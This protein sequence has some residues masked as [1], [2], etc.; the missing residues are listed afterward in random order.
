LTYSVTI[1]LDS[2]IKLYTICYAALTFMFNKIV[3][4]LLCLIIAQ[5]GHGEKRYKEG[6]IKINV[7]LLS[8]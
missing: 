4:G 6:E 3:E 5:Y 7:A 1:A 8:E 2:L